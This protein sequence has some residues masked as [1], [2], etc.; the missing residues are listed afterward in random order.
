[1]LEQLKKKFLSDRPELW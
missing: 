1:M